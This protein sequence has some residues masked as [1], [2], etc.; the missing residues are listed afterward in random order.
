M[1]FLGFFFF[2]PCNPCWCFPSL[3]LSPLVFSF[4][5]QWMMPLLPMPS[6]HLDPDEFQISVSNLP[7]PLDS[8][9]LHLQL[10]CSYTPQTQQN[11]VLVSI[12]HQ[13]SPLCYSRCL[14]MSAQTVSLLPPFSSAT[15]F[16][17]PLVKKIMQ[18]HD[19]L[20]SQYI[21]NINPKT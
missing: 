13:P 11:Q 8:S 15:I 17:Q 5:F 10:D 7:S 2:S 1:S 19:T 20:V 21:N 14:L 3:V 16:N 9:F 12:L 18:P 6:P 4:L